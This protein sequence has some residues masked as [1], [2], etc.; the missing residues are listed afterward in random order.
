MTDD[1]VFVPDPVLSSV[2]FHLSSFFLH[3]FSLWVITSTP[4]LLKPMRLMRALSLGRRNRRGLSFPACGRG[5]T[6]PISIKPKPSASSS[7]RYLAFL[8]KPAPRPTGFL[9]VRPKSWVGSGEGGVK[10]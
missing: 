10:V 1:G 3:A 8:S 9:K 2:I 5:V 7:R 4:S 6:V